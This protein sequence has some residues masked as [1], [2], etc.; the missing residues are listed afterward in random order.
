MMNLQVAP[1]LKYFAGLQSVTIYDY[2]GADVVMPSY[3]GP[4]PALTPAR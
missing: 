2:N 4:F 1:G 3:M